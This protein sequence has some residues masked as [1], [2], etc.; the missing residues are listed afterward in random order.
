MVSS[1]KENLIIQ[2]CKFGL[3]YIA[4][5]F[6]P[7]G[8]TYSIGTRLSSPSDFC[9]LCPR[10]YFQGWHRPFCLP[11]YYLFFFF[12]EIQF[13]WHNDHNDVA[14][15]FFLYQ[16]THTMLGRTIDCHTL[17]HP[18]VYPCSSCSWQYGHTPQPQTN[19]SFK[20]RILSIHWNAATRSIYTNVSDVLV[21]YNSSQCLFDARN[22]R[23]YYREY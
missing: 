2:C 15:Y 5:V 3:K 20:S 11:G 9:K 10:S 23:D 13:E 21:T 18:C 6:R 12:C 7:G 16:Q 17:C 14:P 19:R 8:S 4:Y 22:T 1:L